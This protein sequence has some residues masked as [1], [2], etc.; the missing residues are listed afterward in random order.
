MKEPAYL[1]G[2]FL[3]QFDRLHAYYARHVSGKEDGLR[4]LLGNSL[5]A[6]ALARIFE[7]DHGL[8][9][10]IICPKNLVKMWEDY[11]DQYR[12]RARILPITQVKK[13]FEG[14]FRR[15][16]YCSVK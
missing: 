12:M 16:L 3:A 5:M 11:K 10:L 13:K 6:T 2:R 4:Q 8:E 14:D 7:D 15:L 9:T 1:I